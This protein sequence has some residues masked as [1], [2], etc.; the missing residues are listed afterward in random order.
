M[1]A[2]GGDRYHAIVGRLD[3]SGKGATLVEDHPEAGRAAS[4]HVRFEL[5]PTAGGG[6]VGTDVVLR[7]EAAQDVEGVATSGDGRDTHYVID[8][9]A[10]SH[11]ERSSS[12]RRRARAWRA[13]GPRPRGGDGGL[14]AAA[15][16]R[17][18]CRALGHRRRRR[19]LRA[20]VQD[21]PWRLRSSV[22]AGRQVLGERAG[23]GEG[24]VGALGFRTAYGWVH[25]TRVL[26]SRRFRS[27]IAATLATGDPGRKLAVRVTPD[28]E[29]VIAV[30]MRVVGAGGPAIEALGGAFGA[31][32]GERYLGFGERSNAVD[33]RGNVVEN[34]VSDGPYQAE[35]SPAGA[36]V[37]PPAGLPPARRRHLL[38]DPVAA[39]DRG[40]RRPGRQRR[41]QL[42]PACQPTVA[43]AWSLEVARRAASCACASS[44]GRDRP[45]R[46][47]RFTARDGPPAARRPRPG[48]FGPWYQPSGEDRRA[49]AQLAALRAADAPVSAAQ[50]YLH[51]LPCG[52]QQG[53][54]E[55]SATRTARFHAT[56]VAV[57]T[58]FNPMICT[59][60][61]PRYGA[62]RT[63][64]RADADAAGQPLRLP[65][66]AHDGLP[67]R[68]V[69]L[70]GAGRGRTSTRACWARRWRTATT[71]G[72]RTSASTRR[73]TRT[74]P[75]ARTGAAMHN[76][77]PRLYHCAAYDAAARAPRPI[78]RFQRSGWTGAARCAQVVWGG[79][80][81][82]DWG[83]DGLASAVRRDSRMGLSGVSRWGSDIGG[84]FS[85]LGD[86]LYARAAGALGPARRGLGRDAH[87]A[88]WLRA[89]GQARGRRSSTP[90]LPIWRRYARLRTQ[91]YPYLAAADAHYGAHRACRSCATSR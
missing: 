84:F 85:L 62:G 31:L 50:T 16:A 26:S 30:R 68:P 83:F 36:G 47:A 2:A 77:Y 71:A 12:S 45:T 20:V 7:F 35:G 73:S 32:A 5:P 21:D 87:P 1:H 88:R 74:P 17:P 13:G 57:T 63:R 81:T 4:T 33:Q 69:R 6:A 41:D 64:G 22:R 44:P 56:G 23:G 39:L 91:L 52:D 11:C 67:R 55:R 51:Y 78:V 76:R 79:D 53:R 24:P 27:G 86:Q 49:A 25:A 43:G 54:R 8:Q 65:L 29:G 48:C 3:A 37:I 18:G 75:T 42:L 46:C 34:Y 14:P 9:G 82:T 59:G 90:P 28:G 61:A 15:F 80:P 72:W 66:P 38:P 70:L 58:Y 89:S 19:W 10:R 60:Y 40:L